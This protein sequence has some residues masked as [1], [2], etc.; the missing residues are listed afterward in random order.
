PEIGLAYSRSQMVLP[1]GSSGGIYGENA[2]ARRAPFGIQEPPY[3]C[4]PAGVYR[5]AVFERCGGFDPSL[6]T[7]N[8]CDMAIRVS[9]ICKI[10]Q[11]PE[12]L[13]RVYIRVRSQSRSYA[14]EIFESACLRVSF[15][16]LGRELVAHDR[17]QSLASAYLM[18]GIMNHE[19]FNKRRARKFFLISFA[20]Y[21]TWRAFGFILK[22]FVPVFLLK[23]IR[24]RRSQ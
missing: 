8:D 16:A 6:R 4:V 21:P 22:T 2:I 13:V 9:E 5:R 24:A 18:C 7:Y 20:L 11:T 14:A 3:F 23:Q 17:E 15:K 10:H 12:E 1:D 19:R